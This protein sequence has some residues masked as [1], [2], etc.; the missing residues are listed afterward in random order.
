MKKIVELL[1]SGLLLISLTSCHGRPAMAPYV[2]P[3]TFDT[4]RTYD[5][6][7]WAKNDSNPNQIKI[8]E[9]A[10]EDFHKLY[11]NINVTLTNFIS[12]PDLYKNILQKI[13]T[14]TTP[15]VAIAYPDH[16]ASYL[17][18]PNMVVDLNT[19]IDDKRFGLGGSEIKFDGIKK[20][21]LL[22]EYVDEL[23]LMQGTTKV[24]SSLP[25][26]RSTEVLYV[27]KTWI[28]ENGFE[29]PKDNI[30][31]WDYV[32]EICYKAIEIDPTMIPFIYQSSDN[33][34]IELCYQNGYSYTTE[35]GDVLFSNENNIKMVEELY[36][37][38]KDGLF[39][40]KANTGIY[41]GDRFN[42]GRCIFGV[43]S[44][45]GSTWMGPRSPLG[46]ASNVDFEVV[47]TTVPQVDLNNIKT[48][49]QGPSLCLFNKKD[50]QE[51][52]ASWLFLQYLL[53]NDIQIAYA[54]TEGYSPVTSKAINSSEFKAMLNDDDMYSVQRDAIQN[55]I[56]FKDYTFTT[57]AFNGSAI[58][59]NEVGD[60]INKAC[61]S[62]KNKPNVTNI[63]YEAMVNCGYIN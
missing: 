23:Y 49:S 62:K 36:K 14:D 30:F 45:A 25:F 3:E 55:I 4:S 5:I 18:R 19:I 44:T 12:Y 31:T 54:S 2:M 15:N 42:K 24:L 8:Y 6:S 60:I 1:L 20:E 39:A 32:W 47:V 57:P 22:K 51:V 50:D 52:L 33:F 56:E 27:N 10:I 7:F 26:M 53:T 28:E 63:F 13:A 41:P 21:D 40:L 11:P 48:I 38:Y 37:L 43:D 34:F 35:N 29:M 46:A 17:E 59:R 9:E 16:V 61:K 58:V